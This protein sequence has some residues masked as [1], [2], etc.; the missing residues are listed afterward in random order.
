M[1]DKGI[2]TLPDNLNNAVKYN[3][4]YKLEEDEW[5]M[6]KHLSSRDYC[7][8]ILKKPFDS[9]DYQYVED[10]SLNHL[11][12]LCSY[13]NNN[14]FYFQR[15]CK[16]RILKNRRFLDLSN[17]MRICETG[18]GLIINDVP[19][20]LYLKDA[21]TLYFQSLTTIA[22]IFKGIEILYREATQ[23][24]VDD[25]LDKKFIKMAGTYSSEKV[26]KANR[27]R[28]AMA[29]DTLKR[30]SKDQRKK[31]FKYTNAYYPDLKYDGKAFEIEN[32]D[33][34][35]K[36]LYGIDQRYYTTPVT[37]EKRVANSVK[38]IK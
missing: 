24:E 30:L 15:I 34:L 11:E 22:P 27:H 3:A 14:E 17:D 36:L 4:D 26:G 23:E 10:K 9:T 7:L 38:K 32:E 1:S 31:L 28:I 37:N 13:Q 12:Y 33:D 21:D 16:S 5:Y 18:E 35:K 8:D 20:A 25:F 29:S 2:Y 19:D 6:I